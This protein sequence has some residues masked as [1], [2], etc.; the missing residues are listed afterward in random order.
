MLLRAF[1]RAA[2]CPGGDFPA[3]LRQTFETIAMGKVSANAADARK[4]TFLR[5]TDGVTMNRD[6]LLA[7]GKHRILGL[8]HQGFVKPLPPK[9]MVAYGQRALALLKLGIHLARRAEQITDYDA[10]LG[11]KLA[12][13]LCGGDCSN[14]Q[15][16]SED[17][18]LDLEREAFLSLCGEER[19]QARIQHMLETGKPLKN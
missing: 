3:H 4:L 15:E 13:V 19:T 6:R 12:F 1:E 17:Y 18:V 8:L 10:Q 7:D 5:E 16:V 9:G 11:T 14:L 2:G